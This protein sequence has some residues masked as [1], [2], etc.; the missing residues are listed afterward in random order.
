MLPTFSMYAVLKI[1]V[2][3]IKICIQYAKQFYFQY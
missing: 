2:Y 3:E 1:T